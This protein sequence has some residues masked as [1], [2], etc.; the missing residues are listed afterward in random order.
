MQEARFLAGD[1]RLFGRL[2]KV[3]RETSTGVTR[4]FL[5]TT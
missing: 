3:L 2:G 5:E 4:Q 1:R